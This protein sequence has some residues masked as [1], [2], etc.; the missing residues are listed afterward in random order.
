MDFSRSE[1]KFSPEKLQ[2]M[3]SLTDMTVLEPYPLRWYLSPTPNQ[4]FLQS[5]PT[6]DCG[7]N[8]SFEK[9]QLAQISSLEKQ[10][11]VTVAEISKNVAAQ[12]PLQSNEVQI[13]K[14]GKI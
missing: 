12:H 7:Q 6:E 13:V 11:L 8:F 10:Q 5:T 14:T 9:S 1:M 4:H 3:D 2:Y